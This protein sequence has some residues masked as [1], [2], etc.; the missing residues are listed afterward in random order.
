[1][2]PSACARVGKATR[3]GRSE[4]RRGRNRCRQDPAGGAGTQF[5]R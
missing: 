4:R 3:A 1:L 5:G 2:R